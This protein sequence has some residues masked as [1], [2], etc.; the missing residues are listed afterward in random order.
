MNTRLGMACLTIGWLSFSLTAGAAGLI[1]QQLDQP[2]GLVATA[3]AAPYQLSAQLVGESDSAPTYLIVRVELPRDSY[4][5]SLTQPGELAT[6]VEVA[7]GEDG[8]IAGVMRP[9]SLPKI[10]EQDEFTG[11]RSEKHHGTIHFVLPIQRL[12]SRPLD[13]WEVAV[14]VNGQV[15]SELGSC[16]LIRDEIVAAKFA[17]LDK[18]M[19]D[20]LRQA[21]A[22]HRPLIR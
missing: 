7:L 10:K 13:Q 20:L 17:P 3:E 18:Q 6:R 21:E 16:Q 15:C 4:L 22:S 8:Q 5:Y 14:R 11:G 1:A 9:V 2:P 12:S 19:G